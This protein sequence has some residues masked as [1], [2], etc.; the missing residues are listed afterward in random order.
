M[1]EEMTILPDVSEL[2]KMD[3]QM[4]SS[5][6][7]SREFVEGLRRTS[8]ISGNKRSRTIDNSQDNLVVP[9]SKETRFDSREVMVIPDK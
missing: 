4:L 8:N 5:M 2:D 7:L 6:G 9:L 3:P 1:A